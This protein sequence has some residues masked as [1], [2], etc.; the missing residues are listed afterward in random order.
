MLLRD[1]LRQESKEA[2]MAGN[3]PLVSALRF[4]ISLLDKK[5][6]Q[7]P[8]GKMTEADALS[9]LAKELKNKNEAKEM[10]EKAERKDLVEEVTYEISVLEKYLPKMLSEEEVERSVEE[11]LSANQDANFGQLMGMAMAKLAGKADGA[12]VAELLKKKTSEQ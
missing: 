3:K 1:K 6:L 10:F 5:E 7:L 11:V 4:L 2:L 8:P 9:V 12:M